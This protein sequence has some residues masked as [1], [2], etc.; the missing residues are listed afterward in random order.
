[1]SVVYRTTQIAQSENHPPIIKEGIKEWVDQDEKDISSEDLLKEGD[2][3]IIF[4]SLVTGDHDIVGLVA[5]SI[6]KQNKQDW[7]LAFIKFK[8]RKPSAAEIA[9]YIIGESTPRRL[10]IYRH[11]AEA[12][13]RGRGPEVSLGLG[14]GNNLHAFSAALF[15]SPTDL[16][17]RQLVGRF[18][19]YMT[20]VGMAVMA[21]ILAFRLGFIVTP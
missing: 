21:V 10:A 12:T 18:L 19:G 7:L 4:E 20:L 17:M 15:K 16:S 13:L 9:S 8:K 3:N 1:M 14:E 6:Y 5:Y 2:H 11:L